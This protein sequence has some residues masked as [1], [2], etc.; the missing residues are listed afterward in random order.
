L[1]MLRAGGSGVSVVVA[2]VTAVVTSLVTARVT[3][4]LVAGFVVL[5]FLGAGLQVW[6]TVVDRG[7]SQVRA[8]GAGS[9][10][11]GG[12]NRQ[13]ITTRVSGVWV[14]GQQPVLADDEG[15]SASG[16]GAVAVGGDSQGPIST[17]VSDV[18][19]AAGP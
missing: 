16:V 12:S 3:V 17:E 9:V 10:A 8:A 2:A 15:V 13:L 18:N 1:L 4:M 11:V 14:G 19:R 7:A 5:V 6:L